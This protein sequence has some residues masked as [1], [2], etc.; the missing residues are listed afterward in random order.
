MT[1]EIIHDLFCFDKT[2]GL[3]IQRINITVLV[4]VLSL[5]IA[6]VPS[7]KTFAYISTIS[8]CIIFVSLI[9]IFVKNVNYLQ[10]QK[11]NKISL[12]DRS[13]FYNMSFVPQSLGILL[14][15]FEGITLYLPLKNTYKNYKNFHKFFVITMVFVAFFVFAVS[16]PSYYAFFDKTREIIFLNFDPS[17]IYLHIMKIIY[18]TIVFLSNPINLF[19]LYR[20]V[21]TTNKV[22][23]YLKS[24]SKTFHSIFK[25]CLRILITLVCILIAAFVPSFIKFISFVGS[26]FFS[27]LGIIIPLL[28]YLTHFI[29]L[30]KLGIWDG[31]VKCLTLAVSF[32]LFLIS[33]V[34]SFKSL[35]HST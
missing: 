31:I 22:K 9:I 13:L 35:I 8:M 3:C 32:V 19:P 11:E 20:S 15:S 23:N 26:F 10:T 14:Y 5:L 25:L 34:F 17:Y 21:L 18:L 28:L 7:L 4:G 29:R 2:T 12:V 30:D 1:S 24:K 27:L 16:V 6:I 33:T